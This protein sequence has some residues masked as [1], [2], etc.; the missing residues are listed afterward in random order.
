[1][2]LSRAIPIH[3][4]G[5]LEVTAA[6]LLLVAPFALGFSVAAGMVSIA[7]GVVLT[8]LAL[9]IYG[10]E[11]QGTASV[12]LGAHAGLDHVLAAATIVIG[13]L[14]GVAGDYIA[15]AFLVGFGA[16]HLA[17]TAFTRYSRPLGA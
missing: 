3:I 10:G 7:L 2:S 13:L 15:S 11:N 17:L 6:P 8:G 9:S 14:T 1:M 5:A 16:A 12:P 4:H